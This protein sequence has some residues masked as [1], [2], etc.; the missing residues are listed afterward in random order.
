MAAIGSME[1]LILALIC[2]VPLVLVLL[3]ALVVL[4]VVLLRK[5]DRRPEA[6]DNRV[7]TQGETHG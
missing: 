5:N 6:G 4:A 2:L 1:L 7:D 3:A